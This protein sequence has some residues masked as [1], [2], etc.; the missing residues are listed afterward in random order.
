MAQR[1]SV[2]QEE[3]R[4][5]ESGRGSSAPGAASA[6]VPADFAALLH[7]LSRDASAAALWGSLREQRAS[8]RLEIVQGAAESRGARARKL[9]AA[10]LWDDDAGVALAAVEGLRSGG[11]PRAVASL[12]W[13]AEIARVERVAAAARGAAA[14]LRARG[15]ALLAPAGAGEYWASFID[16]DGAQLL[17]AVRPAGEGAHGERRRLAS[18]AVSDQRGILDASGTDSVASD[19]VEALRSSGCRGSGGERP[20]SG[21]APFPTGESGRGE[22]PPEIGWVRVD[23]AYCAAAVEAARLIHRRDRRRLPG[24]WEFWRDDF[25]G[26]RGTAVLALDDRSL[27]EG[28]LRRRL[29]QTAPLI[30]FE[31]FRSWLILGEDLAPFLPAAV[32]ALKRPPPAREEGVA[33]AISSCL[34]CVIKGRQR[35]LWRSRLLRQAALWERRGDRRVRELCL[36]AAW[37]LDDRNHVPPEQ[38][39]LLRA[40][41][42]ASLEIALGF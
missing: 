39:P 26:P 17:M 28:Q 19:E 37:G 7:L 40:M 2:P 30:H 15:E 38:H 23:G 6:A 22:E 20:R 12:E 35:R 10:A 33:E 34:A 21:P 13:L 31:G 16:G 11:D 32:A 29:P 36:A 3:D 42:R 9:L 18:V 1:G 8:R 25:C 4:R 41:T 27:P 5:P 24:A 14:E